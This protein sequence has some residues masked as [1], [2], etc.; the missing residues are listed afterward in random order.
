MRKHILTHI[1]DP[2][3]LNQLKAVL[4]RSRN[5]VYLLAFTGFIQFSHAQCPAGELKGSVFLDLNFNGLADAFKSQVAIRAFDVNN[6]LVSQVVTDGN[7]NFTITGLSN[8]KTYRLEMIKPQGF[9]YANGG[10]QDVQFCTTPLCNIK[11]GLQDKKTACNPNTA[12]VF[13]SCFVQAGTSE[14]APTLV[15]FPFQFNAASP[16]TKLAMQN[17][18]GSVW[19]PGINQSSYCILQLL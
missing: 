5:I 17:Q 18:T 1:I 11:F 16:I 19:G 12:K 10:L 15:Q 3:Q 14:T 2:I 7:G 6:L 9:E 13:T 4:L 8:N